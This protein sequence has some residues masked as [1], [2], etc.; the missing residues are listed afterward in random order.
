[1]SRQGGTLDSRSFPYSGKALLLTDGGDRVRSMAFDQEGNINCIETY[2]LAKE[3]ST[4]AKLSVTTTYTGWQADAFRAQL[5]YTSIQ[6]TENRYLSYYSKLYP[7]IE[8]ADT[9]IITDDRSI[10]Q[11]T[12]EESYLVPM[13]LSLDSVSKQYTVHFYA[14]FINDH[15]PTIAGKRQTPIAVNYPMDIDYTIR[16]VSPYGWNFRRESFFIDRDSCLFG[17]NT[18][19]KGDTLIV[20]YQFKFHAPEVS[21]DRSSEFISD[22]KSLTDNQL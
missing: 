20:N 2:S 6:E 9:L 8:T 5:A 17:S 3:D 10:N 13:F 15:L 22:V 21:V 14:N 4:A 12:V 7:H 16:V 1:I 19:Y 18:K 11:I